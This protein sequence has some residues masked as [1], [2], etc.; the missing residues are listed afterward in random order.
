MKTTKEK[1]AALRV[2]IKQQGLDGFIIPKADEYQG[3]FVAPCAE[4][5]QWL[6]GFTGSAGI[7]VVLQ[8]KACVLTDGRYRL[9]VGAQVDGKVFATG[10]SIKTGAQGWLNEH[11]HEGAKIGFDPWL[12]TPDE[13]EKLK[14][15][16]PHLQWI[17]VEENLIDEIWTGQPDKP[18]GTVEIFPQK[19]A[20]MPCREKKAQVA[21]AVESAGARAAILTL[22]DSI[23]WLLNVRGHDIDYIPSV[24]SYAVVFADAAQPIWWIVDPAKCGADIRAYGD[25]LF[26]LETLEDVRTLTEGPVML[27]FARSPEAFREM[28]EAQ[29]LE[30]INKKDPCIDFKAVKSEAE[31]AALKAAHILDAIAL[32]KFLHW[33][34]ERAGQGGQ[35]EVSVADK[36]HKFRAEN[37]AFKGPSFPTISG[38]ADNGAIVHYRA[39]EQTNKKLEESGLLLIDSGGQYCNDECAGTTD[40]TRTIAIGQPSDET[41][42][43]FT[44]VL[45]GHIALAMAK[46]PVGTTG[47]QIDA[48]ARRP[49]W[50]ENLDYAHGTGHGVGCYLAV[51]EEAAGISPRGKDP[52]KAGMLI[53]NEPG[54]YK[55]GSHG[56]RIENLVLVCEGQICPDT[57]AQM[58]EFETVSFAPIDRLLIDTDMLDTDERH[59]L[60]IY[61]AQL[62]KLVKDGLTRAEQEWLQ[63]ATRPL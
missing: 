18:L 26:K 57:G 35:D 41:R 6:T 53:S 59:W 56:I 7:A 8:D 3:E 10:D 12:H 15:Q 13:L 22:P 50:N 39:T 31:I 63:E 47:A 27:D 58:L 17:P 2:S 14:A 33:L 37:P 28:L 19:L 48:L 49:L 40:I 1:I 62:Y 21:R 36:L 30:I 55:D 51:H 25:G 34:D 38:F 44:L 52:F 32:V 9:Q 42:R 45:K 61:H 54:Y 24:L 4:R 23:A 5:L 11:A 43:H 20:G 46:F 29:G 16:C 60:N